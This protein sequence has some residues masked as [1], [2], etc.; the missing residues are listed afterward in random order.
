MVCFNKIKDILS[1][2]PWQYLFL[3]A[4][5]FVV[6]GCEKSNS[7]T[8][9]SD[10]SSPSS[11][12]SSSNIDNSRPCFIVKPGESMVS[13]RDKIRDWRKKSPDNATRIAEVFIEGDIKF[14]DAPLELG[15][16][17]S[18][19]IWSSFSGERTKVTLMRGRKITDWKINE[20]GW[21]ETQIPAVAD[22]S[23]WFDQLYVNDHRAVRAK[24]PNRFWY[25]VG[26]SVDFMIDPKTNKEIDASHRAFIPRQEQLSLFE[27]ITKLDPEKYPINDIQI[28]FFH[29]WASSKHRIGSYDPKNQT[30]LLT[31][32]AC[33]TLDS[34]GR[35]KLRYEVEGIPEALDIPG[36][37]L[38]NREG[39]LL[40]IP[41]KGETLENTTFYAPANS[42][43]FEDNGFLR[44]TG[45]LDAI[46]LEE[47]TSDNSPLF[48]QNITFH[49]INFE[50]DS[51]QLPE[52]GLSSGQA[53]IK[54]PVSIY[55]EAARNIKFE[56]CR[57]A[58]LGGYA[59]W[60]H[61]ACRQCQVHQCFMDD[62]GAGGVRIGT[63]TGDNADNILTR[64]MEVT[65]NV[66]HDYGQIEAS[67]IGVWLGHTADNKVL[68]NDISNGFY[69]GISLG[70][71]WGYAPS[72]SVNNK[73]EFNH[74]HHIGQGVLSDMGGVYSLGISTG[75]TVSNNRI[76]DVYSYNRYG[77]GGW[78]LYTDEGSSNMTF[79]N[80][81]VYRVHTGTVHQHY[82]QGNIFRNNILAYSLDGQIQRSRHE[83]HLSFT[84]ENNII[85]WDQGP[86]TNSQW[87]VNEGRYIL[88]NNLYWF[89]GEPKTQEEKDRLYFDGQ[90]LADWQKKGNDIGSRFADPNFVNPE[91]G[92]FNFKDNQLNEAVKAIGFKPFNYSLA[93]LSVESKQR[94]AKYMIDF[95]YPEIEF[96]DDPPAPLPIVLSDDFERSRRTLLPKSSS[97]TQNLKQNWTLSVTELDQN[98]KVGRS[99]VKSKEVPF[100]SDDWFD[101]NW[102]GFCSLGTKDTTIDIDNISMIEKVTA[103]DKGKN[104]I[105]ENFDN[106]S[107]LPVSGAAMHGENRSNAFT[108]PSDGKGKY[109]RLTD[110]PDFQSTFNPH[111]YYELDRL[112]KLVKVTFD[113]RVSS[114][115]I[116]HI[117]G[118]DRIQ[119]GR[120]RIGPSLLLSEG[121]IQAG[122]TELG[123]IPENQWVRIEM[124]F[125][126]GENRIRPACQIVTE[127]DNKFLRINDNGQYKFQYEPF[128][129]YAPGYTS[130]TACVRF[131]LRLSKDA[132]FFTEGRDNN[133]PYRTC[134]QVF[135]DNEKIKIS[136]T[137]LGKYRSE[138]WYEVTLRI[139]IA[140]GNQKK[141]ELSI[142]E[143]KDDG[144][145][146]APFIDKKDIAIANPQWNGLFWYGFVANGTKPATIDLDNI[147]I[148]LQ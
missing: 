100:V 123:I 109:L 77:R 115:A 69:T 18:N 57:L 25:Y 110:S 1:G 53:A 79:E 65:D 78:G 126:T 85:L 92:D 2:F 20:K 145:V 8:F 140:A 31:G 59:F 91:K 4:L 143:I 105:E 34:W 125:P 142:A 9:V 62:M 42:N 118:R 45:D 114:G 49:G 56:Q 7:K 147:D 120:Y 107:K 97:Q 35:G 61:R 108:L 27:T 26:D 141:C 58:H 132:V 112:N 130:G 23:W 10:S 36:E 111:F 44:I 76:H 39:T 11:K 121:K 98:G 29:S 104:I 54:T 116:F 90:S 16:Q 63:A 99:I 87:G 133:S 47:N 5:I 55:V 122:S 48:V 93:G 80:N 81:L 68:Y 128:I 15:P 148:H 43:T 129:T 113:V 96:A 74:I 24:T 102:F 12:V 51:F 67:A 136:G 124:E 52:A 13:A 88:R 30:V 21:F 95:V 22:G 41:R 73:I 50:Y 89:T 32:D 19:V 84:L 14:F 139:P 146:S 117:E 37:F 71:V 33:W 119:N 40:Y 101:L 131:R 135:F 138:Q 127:K 94:W 3:S 66:I 106:A 83:D 72:K 82:G 144:T 60:F 86:L 64:N 6:L 28:R 38:L 75:T 103:E 17:D 46:K 70:W 137:E 134:I